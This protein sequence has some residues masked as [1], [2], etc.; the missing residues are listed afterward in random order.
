MQTA[1]EHF[2]VSTD[3]TFCFSVIVWYLQNRQMASGSNPFMVPGTQ[4]RRVT[5]ISLAEVTSTAF[6]RPQN[7]VSKYSNSFTVFSFD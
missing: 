6:G 4:Q 1:A 3:K 7:A 5:Y 2:N